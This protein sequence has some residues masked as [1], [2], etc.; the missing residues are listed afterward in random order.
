MTTFDTLMM[1]AIAF[2][3]GGLVGSLS[4]WSGLLDEM[5]N[6]MPALPWKAKAGIWRFLRCPR[7]V[8]IA[9]EADAEY[10]E[11]YGYTLV[12]V[13]RDLGGPTPIPQT[14]AAMDALLVEAERRFQL[15]L[16][17]RDDARAIGK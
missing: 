8:K 16:K 1:Q 3:F 9:E 11:A 13:M 14:Q 15:V 12:G 17:E 4:M 2:A 6:N 5:L 10:R 7:F